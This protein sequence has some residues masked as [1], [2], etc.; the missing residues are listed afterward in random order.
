MANFK[1]SYKLVVLHLYCNTFPLMNYKVT[2]QYDS[3]YLLLEPGKCL[4]VK[5]PNTFL[6]GKTESL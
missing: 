1:Y 5:I 3:F 2:V 4:R 6:G